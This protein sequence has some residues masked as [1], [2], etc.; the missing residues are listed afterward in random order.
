MTVLFHNVFGQGALI[1]VLYTWAFLICRLQLFKT[2]LML[3]G[4]KWIHLL[5]FHLYSMSFFAPHYFITSGICTNA[6]F[7]S[8]KSLS[9][10]ALR[11]LTEVTALTDTTSRVCCDDTNWFTFSERPLLGFWQ[12]QK[13]PTPSQVEQCGWQ[14]I[15]VWST[16]KLTNIYPSDLN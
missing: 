15:W 7:L 16:P 4:K 10:L 14:E 13:C 8:L 3:H 6:E 1:H 2:L 5:R 12:W 9:D 11:C